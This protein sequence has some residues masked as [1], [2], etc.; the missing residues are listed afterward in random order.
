MTKRFAV[1]MMALLMLG[2]CSPKEPVQNDPWLEKAPEPASY[3]AEADTLTYD[4]LAESGT[5]VEAEVAPEPDLPVLDEA[6][7]EAAAEM[8]TPP[9]V[10]QPEAVV[11]EMSSGPLFYVQVFASSNRKSAEEVALKADSRLDQTVRILFLD[12]YY[13]VLVGGFVDKDEAV[14]LR[15]DLTEIGYTDAWIFEH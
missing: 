13:K 14:V 6:P 11:P 15:R 10:A 7:V 9:P 2:A 4:F 3:E 1:I 8:T 12:P 5:E